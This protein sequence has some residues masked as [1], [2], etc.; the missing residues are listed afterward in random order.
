MCWGTPE[1]EDKDPVNMDTEEEVVEVPVEGQ[2]SKT[3]FSQDVAEELV[4]RQIFMDG[5]CDPVEDANFAEMKA[6]ASELLDVSN[7]RKYYVLTI[8]AQ[9]QG[10]ML[11]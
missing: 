4:L 8:G 10:F 2:C 7:P 9:E 3:P 1:P 6:E 11:D 5:D